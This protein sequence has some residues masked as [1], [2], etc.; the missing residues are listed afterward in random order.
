MKCGSNPGLHRERIGPKP[1]QRELAAERVASGRPAPLPGPGTY[2]QHNAADMPALLPDGS[3]SELSVSA[4][5]TL[6]GA[7]APPELPGGASE[8]GHAGSVAP[9][10]ADSHEA[11]EQ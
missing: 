7:E 8:S 1:T 11:G 6:R 5:L 9:A 4:V 3:Q 10:P 2:A